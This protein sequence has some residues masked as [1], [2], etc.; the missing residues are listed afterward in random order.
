MEANQVMVCL[1]LAD[2][3]MSLSPI[4][5]LIVRLFMP[6]SVSQKILQTKVFIVRKMEEKPGNL[7]AIQTLLEKTPTALSLIQRR[8]I[9][10]G[11]SGVI[12]SIFLTILVIPGVV[13]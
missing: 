5:R 8:L 1:V 4:R 12:D 11:W 7:R 6:Q 9:K 10:F 3:E 13:N 2:L